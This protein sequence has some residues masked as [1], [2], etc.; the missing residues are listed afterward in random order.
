MNIIDI[1]PQ[2]NIHSDILG[3]TNNSKRVKKNYIF[4]AIKGK[5]ENGQKYIKEALENGASL[6]ITDQLVLGKYN[7]LRV[8]NAKL[9]YIYLLQKFYHYTNNIYTIGITGTDGK[10][11][12]A[13]ML[14]S[15]FNSFVSSAYIGTNGINYLNKTIK[16]PNTTPTPTLLYPAYQVFRK[17][18]INNMILEVSS[19]GILD[20]R[21][22]KFNF[23][24]A[25]YTNLSLE[26]LNTHK[27]MDEYFKC[28]AK[29]FQAI[30]ENGLIAINTD[31]F[32]AHSIPFYTKANII[33]Y[34]L[35]SGLYRAKN[36]VLNFE[37]SEFD[38]FY[39]GMFLTHICLPLFGKYNIYNALGCIAYTYE[40]GIDIK[41][42]K[43]GLE[44]LSYVD[45][46]FMHYVSKD[47]ITAIVDFAHTPNALLNIYENLKPFKKGKIIHVLGAAGE[48]D[49]LKRA[50]MGKIA[51]DNADITIFTSE[52]P[53]NEN[54]FQILLDLT[55][56]LEDKE[57]YIT[58]DRKEAIELAARI[59]NPKDIILITGKGN[60]QTETILN[61]K[62]THNDF[63]II[64]KALKKK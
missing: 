4:V 9:E 2:L 36:I 54:I 13:T 59:A 57:Y 38:V 28:K 63:D 52:D 1:Y 24:G 46:R 51:T 11:T 21:I 30:N 64:K 37:K 31:D 26:H 33:T 40:L 39:Q 20:G 61:Y 14:N 34:G 29:L 23:N 17:H 8:K 18:N 45:G 60:E 12:T 10:T 42:I 49:F 55:K 56:K 25:I 16:T 62:F 41:Y 22:E 53:K 32:Y 44:K 43:E 7:H 15:I 27:T 3:I 35:E 5:K 47:N 19:E 48:K 6:I 58:I 50:D